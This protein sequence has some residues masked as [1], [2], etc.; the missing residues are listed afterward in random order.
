MEL[1]KSGCLKHIYCNSQPLDSTSYTPDPIDVFEFA[2]LYENLQVFLLYG[3]LTVYFNNVPLERD[4]LI[5]EYHFERN[6]INCHYYNFVL[7]D[8]PLVSCKSVTQCSYLDLLD[9][10]FDVNRLI[11]Q[12]PTTL[13]ELYSNI[14][15]CVLDNSAS[16]RAIDPE[17]FYSFLLRCDALA[18]LKICNS[19]FPAK[20]Y[21]RLAA[22]D[23]KSLDY[24]NKF[25]LSESVGYAGCLTFGFL[26]RFKYLLRFSTNLATRQRMVELV[27]EMPTLGT[28]GFQF[29][30]NL[31]SLVYDVIVQRIQP[32]WASVYIRRRNPDYV[33]KLVVQKITSFE[34]AIDY[35][36]S[37]AHLFCGHWME[38]LPVVPK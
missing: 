26:K 33:P 10:T 5:E 37:Q 6:L 1:I 27:R 31:E 28:F 7:G 13:F 29:W 19:G 34:N 9:D 14:R 3:H 30:N 35:L 20:W 12:S 4:R 36:T 24:L 11:E 2:R 16:Q 25:V 22:E 38:D 23:L 18:E 21:D 15:V 17:P 32:T 8:R